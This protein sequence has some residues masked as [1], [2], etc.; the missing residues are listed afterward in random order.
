MS[1][2][3]KITRKQIHICV[4]NDNGVYS[5]LP[6]KWL[7]KRLKSSKKYDSTA[8]KNNYMHV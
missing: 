5:P 1:L 7:P 2:T 3:K 8:Y 4:D 6:V